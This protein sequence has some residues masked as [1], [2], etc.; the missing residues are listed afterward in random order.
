MEQLPALR[1]GHRWVAKAAPDGYTM[2]FG[3]NSMFALAPVRIS[4]AAAHVGPA[5]E[6][7]DEQQSSDERHDG[8]PQEPVGRPAFRPGRTAGGARAGD[9]PG[10]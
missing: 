2:L 8:E 3:V 7:G 4:P 9:R 6:P 1:D 5:A 10:R